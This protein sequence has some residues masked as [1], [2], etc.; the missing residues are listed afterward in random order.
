MKYTNF[1]YLDPPAA[2]SCDDEVEDDVKDEDDEL[3]FWKNEEIPFC[4]SGV[5]RGHT[6]F[7]PENLFLPV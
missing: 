4:H 5:G 3:G 7:P 6:G 2:V 1:S